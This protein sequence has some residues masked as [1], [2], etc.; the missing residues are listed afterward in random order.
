MITVLLLLICGAL[1]SQS[2]VHSIRE[3]NLDADYSPLECDVSRVSLALLLHGRSLTTNG[4][5]LILAG[6]KQHNRPPRPI[7][8]CSK[9]NQPLRLKGGGHPPM[10]PGGASPDFGFGSFQLPQFGSGPSLYLPL[11]AVALLAWYGQFS[12]QL[13]SGVRGWS[14]T[15]RERIKATYAYFAASVLVWL[16]SALLFWK[17]GIIPSN[18]WHVMCDILLSCFAMYKVGSTPSD[19]RPPSAHPRAHGCNSEQAACARCARR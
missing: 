1:R 7:K 17:T 6:P 15:T 10:F 11:A 18:G 16:G 8:Q 5:D 14:R 2:L 9:L 3:F 19:H 4:Q 12:A 13:R